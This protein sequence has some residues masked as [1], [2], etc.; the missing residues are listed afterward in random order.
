MIVRKQEV[1]VPS[2]TSTVS[3]ADFLFVVA[4]LAEPL[5]YCP[6]ISSSRCLFAAVSLYLLGCVYNS[7]NKINFLTCLI[8]IHIYSISSHVHAYL[9]VCGCVCGTDISG[10]YFHSKSGR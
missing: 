8:E 3:S 10:V 1:Q 7:N 5:S 9:C 4:Y 2:L 6:C